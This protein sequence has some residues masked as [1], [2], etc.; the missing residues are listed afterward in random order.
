MRAFPFVIHSH[1]RPLCCILL[2]NKRARQKAVPTNTAEKYLCRETNSRASQ[3][4]GLASH[5]INLGRAELHGSGPKETSS[6]LTSTIH[7]GKF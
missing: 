4:T 5:A 6:S 1:N 2:H 3:S 7:D